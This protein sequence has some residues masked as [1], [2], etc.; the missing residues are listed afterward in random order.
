M[1][2]SNTSRCSSRCG[3]RSKERNPGSI[4]VVGDA[5]ALV[6]LDTLV[7]ELISAKRVDRNELSRF[8]S[9]ACV[10]RSARSRWRGHRLRKKAPDVII[11]V[12]A[13]DPTE[14]MVERVKAVVT[15]PY[16]Q[17]VTLVA[18]GGAAAGTGGA[19]GQP[20]RRLGARPREPRSRP[21]APRP[22]S[23]RCRLS[24]G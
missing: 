15:H 12:N 16:V 6:D 24:G 9:G 7:E 20:G 13:D 8:S 21:A 17:R 5:T 19:V 23:P 3:S 18:V 14:Q 11:A 22:Q 1:T 10:L 2:R 4:L